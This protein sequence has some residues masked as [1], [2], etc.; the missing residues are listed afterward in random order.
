MVEEAEKELKDISPK[1]TFPRCPFVF[2]LLYIYPLISLSTFHKL[3]LKQGQTSARQCP[4]QHE[5]PP[6]NGRALGLRAYRSHHVV[7][8]LDLVTF[9]VLA[10][11]P[12]DSAGLT[13]HRPQVR[14]APP[15]ILPQHLL[16]QFDP[17][18]G[19]KALSETSPHRYSNRL[20]PPVLSQE[21]ILRDQPVPR[22]GSMCLC[23]GQS[24]GDTG[25]YQERGQRGKD[26]VRR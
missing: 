15:A 1:I 24:R 7:Q 17:K 16:C 10:R 9:P 5:G 8:F 22:P 21:Q 11:P 20:L 4:E 26:G 12:L 23:G 6:V 2:P 3:T 14:H 19:E 13:S 18:V 25:T